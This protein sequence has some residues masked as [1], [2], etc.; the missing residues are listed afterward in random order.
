[1]RVR[2]RQW[3][4]KRQLT[5]QELA[6]LSGVARQTVGG[7]EAG[8]YGP[9]VEV[10][11]RLANALQCRVEDLFDLGGE[12]VVGVRLPERGRVALTRIGGRAV[13]RGLDGLGGVRWHASIGGGIA[14]GGH[15]EAWAGPTP[16]VFLAGCDPALGLLAAH[17]GLGYW[18]QAGNGDAL[19]QLQQGEV[20]A[21]AVHGR[22]VAPPAGFARFR[23]A[24]W[25]MG[26]VVR[27]G[28]PKGF[29]D[30]DDLRRDD[31]I[32]AGREVGSGAR[33]LLEELGVPPAHAAL[34]DGH[35][36]VAETVAHGLADV[37]IAPAVAAAEYGLDFL[38]LRQEVCDL[39]VARDEPAAQTLIEALQSGHFLADLAAFGPYDTSRTGDEVA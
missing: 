1:M 17:C 32:F 6:R 2:L 33:A 39:L 22:D 7:I 30:P 20:H 24:R 18:W 34:F 9:S 25:E 26:W 14:A 16:A 12:A 27:R 15:V 13:A 21:A 3:R 19:A 29:A 38:P 35:A 8:R 10:G 31:L 37:G 11:L 4:E 36:A 23:L 28:N 5:Q